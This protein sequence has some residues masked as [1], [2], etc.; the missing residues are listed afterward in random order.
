[1]GWNFGI[2]ISDFSDLHWDKVG[3]PGMG[4]RTVTRPERGEGGIVY[5]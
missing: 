3:A 2:V 1:M 5:S 4:Y